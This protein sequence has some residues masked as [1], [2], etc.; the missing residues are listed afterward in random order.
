MT[1]NNPVQVSASDLSLVD[2]GDTVTLIRDT[3]DNSYSAVDV[4]LTAV[5]EGSR[6]I[7][8]DEASEGIREVEVKAL[9]SKHNVTCASL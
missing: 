7:F 3:P 1:F 8:W 6:T 5:E 9:H 4:E 2:V